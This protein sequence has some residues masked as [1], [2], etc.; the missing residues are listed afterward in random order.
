MAWADHFGRLFP[1]T[2]SFGI[3][4]LYLVTSLSLAMLVKASS[5]GAL[6]YSY[7]TVTVVL[8]TELTKL[9][10]SSLIYLKDNSF[11]SLIDSVNRHRGV[12]MLYIVPAGLYCIYNNLYF[13]SL[14]F[15][16]PT[17][18]NLFMQ[19]RLVLTGVIYQVIFKRML[20]CRQW[21]SLLLLTAGCVMQAAGT[22][23]DASFTSYAFTSLGVFGLGITFVISKTVA[24]VFAGVYNE[25]LIKERGGNID[26]MIQNVFLYVHS[27]VWNVLVLLVKGDLASAFTPSALSSICQPLVL[28]VILNITLHGILVSFFLQKLNS[29]LKTFASA[30]VLCLTPVISWPVLGIP[31]TLHTMLAVCV[32]SF[33]VVV[34]AKSP[35]PHAPTT[36]LEKN[37]VLQKV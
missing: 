23:N 12:F 17:S 13:V 5:H 11:F 31:I 32:I 21:G 6:S 22:L 2:G 27:I 8:I 7:N 29:I 14:I 15:F 24:S 37:G 20:S 1:H 9:L 10:L 34:Y 18:N 26:I 4:L 25:F 36:S 35:M 28:A 3:F 33:A 30:I 16:D 19:I